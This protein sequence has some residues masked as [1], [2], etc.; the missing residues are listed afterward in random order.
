MSR[1]YK[2][3]G[4]KQDA[5]D[6][7]NNIIRRNPE[8]S[9]GYMALAS[10]YQDDKEYD[11]AVETLRKASRIRDVNIPLMLGNLYLIKKDYASALAQCRRAEEI[12]SEYVPDMFQKAAVYHTMGKRNDAIAE[13]L[14]VLRYSQNHVAALNNLAF[15]YAEENKDLAAA[16]QV[17]MRAYTLAPR[18]GSVLDTLGFV[19]LKNK[20]VDDAL[21][22]L[23]K[24]A[25][26]LP[27]NPAVYY[28][29]ALGYKEHGKNSLAVENLQKALALGDFSEAGQARALLEKLK[30]GAKG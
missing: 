1:I 22:A 24:A 16:L 23:Q 28:H 15:L 2:I 3:M 5:V 18:D 19:L 20:K 4:K 12:K 21:K 7:A 29:L 13:Y 6:N 14:R 27:D 10:I 25:E 9:A 11:K 8:S 26:F 17:A 30:K